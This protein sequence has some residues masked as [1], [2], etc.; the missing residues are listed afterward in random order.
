MN[1]QDRGSRD[2]I[3]AIVLAYAALAAAWILLSD[4][5]V[6]WLFDD[7][8]KILLASILKGWLFVAVTAFML[9]LVLRRFSS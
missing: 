3:L 5:V 2:G 1:S 8:A 9:F 7:P 6:G 4:R